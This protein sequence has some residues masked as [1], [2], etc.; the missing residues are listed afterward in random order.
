VIADATETLRRVRLAEINREP[1]S[2]AMLEY[3]YGQVW[4]SKELAR[5]FV[6]LGYMAPF[7]VVDR[8]TDGKRGSLAFQHY[9]RFYFNW[10]ADRE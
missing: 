6:V 10:R 3:Q 9:P 8:K 1:A 2:R 5:D 4:D 7:V